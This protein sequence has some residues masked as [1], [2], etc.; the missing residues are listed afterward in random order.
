MSSR[1]TTAVRSKSWSVR[2]EV[3]VQLPNDLGCVLGR[4]SRGA[5]ESV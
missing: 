3:G 4:H 2:E 5:S 1:Y